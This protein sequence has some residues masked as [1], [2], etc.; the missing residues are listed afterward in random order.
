MVKLFNKKQGGL[1]MLNKHEI[2]IK[3]NKFKVDSMERF[4]E[5]ITNVSMDNSTQCSVITHKDG[6]IEFYAQDNIWVYPVKVDKENDSVEYSYDYFLEELSKIVSKNHKIL[7]EEV[8]E[9]GA[10]T[11]T[12]I[13]AGS[14]QILN[15]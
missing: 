3:T 14:I 5:L 8:T 13:K 6:L 2:Y 12:E 9:S 11:I 1:I 4:N 7:L 15:K 10:K